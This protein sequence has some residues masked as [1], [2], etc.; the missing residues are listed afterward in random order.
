[1]STN[2]CFLVPQFENFRVVGNMAKVLP[3]YLSEWTT[4]KVQKGR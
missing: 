1:M 4:K 2:V 3:K